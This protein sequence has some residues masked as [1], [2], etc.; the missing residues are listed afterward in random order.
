MDDSRYYLETSSVRRLWRTLPRI[1]RDLH[2]RVF[3]SYLVMF[4]L[5]SGLTKEDYALRREILKSCVDSKLPI[6]WRAPTDITAAAFTATEYHD[7]RSDELKKLL[8]VVMRC[9]DLAAAEV[10]CSA[11]NLQASLAGLREE[12]RVL[13]DHEVRSRTEMGQ[14]FRRDYTPEERKLEYDKL[15]GQTTSEEG[16]AIKRKMQTTAEFWEVYITARDLAPLLL[17]D[18]LQAKILAMLQSY[19][20]SISYHLR[21]AALAQSITLLRGE[22]PARNDFFDIAHFLYLNDATIMVSDDKLI[23]R[24]CAELWPSRILASEDF[25]HLKKAVAL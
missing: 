17:G 23:H 12:D 20:G 14:L 5:L 11:R 25:L 22:T 6:D 16:A 18:S 24:L 3:S 4:E 13:R 19:D 1:K 10:E 21:A 7:N 9:Q 15:L 8:S 2:C